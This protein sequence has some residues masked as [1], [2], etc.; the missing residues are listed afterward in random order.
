MTRFR[1]PIKNLTLINEFLNNCGGGESNL[2][3]GNFILHVN[4]AHNGVSPPSSQL[5]CHPWIDGIIYFDEG[6]EAIY[7]RTQESL[8]QDLNNT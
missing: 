6:V 3:R 2:S 4:K 5:N 7:S 1:T 8:S